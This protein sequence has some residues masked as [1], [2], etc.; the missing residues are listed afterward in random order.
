MF[1]ISEVKKEDIIKWKLLS[2]KFWSITFDK[3][4]SNQYKV[5]QVYYA[6]KTFGVEKHLRLILT[7]SYAKAF[8]NNDFDKKAM[9][10]LFLDDFKP[11]ELKI[12]NDLL[13]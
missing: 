12:L 10:K 5:E 11:E 7:I 3:K 9:T 4:I 13:V 2:N 8:C 6:L 1:D